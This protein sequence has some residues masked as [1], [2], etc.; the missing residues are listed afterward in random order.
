MEAEMIKFFIQVAVIA[1][2]TLIVI[3]VSGLV[4]LGLSQ[5]I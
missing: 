3:A 1:T 5:H 4:I 2:V